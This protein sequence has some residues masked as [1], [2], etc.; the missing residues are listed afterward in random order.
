MGLFKRIGDVLRANLNDL[1]SKAEDPKKMLEQLV[2]DMEEQLIQAK[3][4]VAS[5]IADEK[6]LG[7]QVQE[8]KELASK[9]EQRAALAVEKGDDSLAMEALKKKKDAE[10][11]AAEYEAQW[12]KQKAVTD[13]LKQSIQQVQ[14]KVEELKRKKNLLIARQKRAEAQDKIQDTMSKM[15]DS[16]AFDSFGRMEEKVKQMEAEADA[17]EELNKTL[18]GTDTEEKFKQLERGGG[19]NLN[20]ELAALKAKLKK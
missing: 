9:W 5:A 20:D 17:K 10:S 4:D 1:I 6:R 19:A 12:Q 8:Q 7:A 14:D 16:S 2:M 13:Q 3:K 15:N 11:L 18:A